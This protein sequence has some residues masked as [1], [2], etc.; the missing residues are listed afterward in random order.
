MDSFA[1]EISKDYPNWFKR[2]AAAGGS[3]CASVVMTKPSH[4]SYLLPMLLSIILLCVHV[5]ILQ[6][7]I[8]DSG[9]LGS[10]MVAIENKLEQ[11]IDRTRLL[12]VL[13]NDN[14]VNAAKG[15][16]DFILVQ[17]DWTVRRMPKWLEMDENYR[18]A[19]KEK[20]LFQC[21]VPMYSEYYVRRNTYE[22][23]SAFSPITSVRPIEPLVRYCYPGHCR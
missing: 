16:R 2:E 7:K 12:G 4:P 10:K 21:G 9:S 23:Y 19:F 14:F 11:N 15:R 8:S 22:N 18:R 13:H 5:V 6:Y 17:K 3:A 20:Y 1:H